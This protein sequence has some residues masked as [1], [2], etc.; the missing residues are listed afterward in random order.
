MNNTSRIEHTLE[1]GIVFSENEI[2]EKTILETRIATFPVGCD[3]SN[4]QIE[5]VRARAA[6][7]VTHRVWATRGVVRHEVIAIVFEDYATFVVVIDDASDCANADHV[8][9]FVDGHENGFDGHVNGFVDGHASDDEIDVL[10]PF[11]ASSQAIFDHQRQ[12]GHQ[13]IVRR[14]FVCPF[15]PGRLL[16]RE[17]LRIG[18]TQNH[19]VDGNSN[20]EGY[21]H[22]LS[23]HIGRIRVVVHLG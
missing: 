12:T 16:R 13:C 8:S 22:P 19:A 3:V 4:R 17:C 10:G 2:C 7:R 6:K 9:G 23:D 1:V 11:L 21:K 5:I 14:L 15:H 20:P 18:H